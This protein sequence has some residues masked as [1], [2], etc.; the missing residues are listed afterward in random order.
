MSSSNSN[1]KS[2]KTTRREIIKIGGIAVATAAMGAARSA[3]LETRAPQQSTTT[4]CGAQTLP[5]ESVFTKVCNDVSKAKYGTGDTAATYRL[6]AL[7]LLLTTED[8][9]TYFRTGQTEAQWI[10]GIA[11]ELQLSEAD[12]TSLWN[13]SKD[14]QLAQAH[15]QGVRSVWQNFTASSPA[16]GHRPCIGGKTALDVACLAGAAAPQ[17]KTS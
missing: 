13:S 9:A 4:C 10:T 7:W 6:A 16:Y 17:S 8:W 12:V 14:P 15:F 2:Q 5:A 1:R 3:A 11:K